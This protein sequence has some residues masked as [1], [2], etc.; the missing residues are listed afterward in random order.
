[1]KKIIFILI[2][3]AVLL[4]SGCDAMLEVFYPE[5]ADD[6]NGTNNIFAVELYLTAADIFAYGYMGHLPLRVEL[7]NNG[8]DPSSPAQKIDGIEVYAEYSFYYEFFITTGHYDL[9]IW[10]DLDA[11]GF[12]AGDFVQQVTVP[13]P[14]YNFLGTDEFYYDYVSTWKNF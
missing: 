13:P 1:M 9:W 14:N 5:F 8:F 6:F 7:Y 11:N 4:F 3:L 2:I 10:Q 12:D